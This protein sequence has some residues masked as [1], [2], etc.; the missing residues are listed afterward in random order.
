MKV[1]M[2]VNSKQAKWLVKDQMPHLQPKGIF[3]DVCILVA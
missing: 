2:I 3:D 1:I